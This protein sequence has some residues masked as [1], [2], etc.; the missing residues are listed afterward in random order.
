MALAFLAISALLQGVALAL[1]VRRAL[2]RRSGAWIVTAAA[3]ALMF[4]RRVFS[5]GPVPGVPKR[6]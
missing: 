5:G 3:L 2:A 6:G 1:A 4:A